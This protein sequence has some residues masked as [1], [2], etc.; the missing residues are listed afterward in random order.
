MIYRQKEQH[1][2]PDAHSYSC[3]FRPIGKSR[4][5]FSASGAVYMGEFDTESL[6]A[7]GI[8]RDTE[9]D[10]CSGSGPS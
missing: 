5:S 7:S 8:G 4:T 6:S 10:S 9:S 2:D 3:S 1:P